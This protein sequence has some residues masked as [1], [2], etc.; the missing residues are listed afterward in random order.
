[1]GTAVFEVLRGQTMTL[2][3]KAQINE[4]GHLAP[5]RPINGLFNVFS[6][7]NAEK[8]AELQISLV[9]E[10]LPVSYESSSSMPTTDMSM[11]PRE[12]DRSGNVSSAS[13]R[14]DALKQQP[15]SYQ[16]SVAST[17][18]PSPRSKIKEPRTN[19]R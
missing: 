14:D 12:S 11:L 1:M 4:I 17:N 19:I 5:T 10:P 6:N 9:F 15:I 18:D 2:M 8:I 16:H 7:K 3:G 13:R